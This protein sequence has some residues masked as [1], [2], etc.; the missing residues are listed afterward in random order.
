MAYSPATIAVLKASGLTDAQIAALGASSTPSTTPKTKKPPK[1]G[2]FERTQESQNIPT[3][4]AIEETLNKTYQKFYG[5]E[6]TQDELSAYLPM[7]IAQYKDPKTGQSKSF[8]KETYKNGQLVDTQVLTQDKKD[9]GLFLENVLK[10]DILQGKTAVNPLS[11]P[12]GPMGKTFVGLKQLA[13]ENGV[14]LSD[15][16]ALDYSQ[17]VAA[18]QIDPTTA[19][20][21]IRDMASSAFP[22]F[23]DKIKAGVNL[24]TLADPYIQSM[25]NILEVPSSSIDLFDPTVRSALSYTAADGKPATKSLYD[26]EQQL[27]NDPRWAKTSN[28]R[29]AMDNVGL[30]VLKNF[31]LAN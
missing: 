16:A 15:E 13:R 29:Q 27:R 22:Q 28:A 7:A 21:N 9:I 2:T 20:N 26:F 31:G 14:N 1:S 25:S 5:R 24:K 8:I 23:S 10:S 3:N 30:Q 4:A 11:I 6:A 17:K 18:E 19:E 12:E